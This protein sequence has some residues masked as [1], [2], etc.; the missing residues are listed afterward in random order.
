MDE[1]YHLIKQRD[2]LLSRFKKDGANVSLYAEFCKVRNQVQ[3]DIKLAKGEYFKK[4]VEQNK[5]DSGK[6]WGHLKSLGYA[7]MSGGSSKIVLD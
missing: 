5:G 2:A 1:F 3:R 4:K 6:L 7:K